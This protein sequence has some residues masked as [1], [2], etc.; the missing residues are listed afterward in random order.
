MLEGISVYCA[1]CGHKKKPRGRSA[2]IGLHMCDSACPG[3]D[4]APRVGDLWPGET[5]EEFGYPCSADGT[6]A[7]AAVQSREGE[8]EVIWKEIRPRLQKLAL[9]CVGTL[10]L[11]AV[12]FVANWYAGDSAFSDD[13][14]YSVNWFGTW[15][16]ALTCGTIVVFVSILI[17]LGLYSLAKWVWSREGDTDE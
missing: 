5:E 17:L 7:S 2:P 6:I 4:E 13:K 8:T 14:R 16:F 10:P 12:W 1:S 11:Y 15:F 9:V 3:Y